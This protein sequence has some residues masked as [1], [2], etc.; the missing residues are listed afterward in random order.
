M[1]GAL[2][3]AGF[4]AEYCAT[5]KE[6]LEVCARK[7]PDLVIAELRLSGADGLKVFRNIRERSDCYLVMTSRVDSEF[8]RL[9][10]LEMGADDFVNK[11]VSVREL[12]ARAA[13]MFRRP[14]RMATMTEP[15]EELECGGGLVVKPWRREALLNEEVLPLTPTEFAMLRMLAHDAGVAC[16]RERI[17]ESVWG[18][19]FADDRHLVDVH[20]SNLRR[21]LEADSLHTWIHTVR[22][23]GYRLDPVA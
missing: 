6:A 4:D 12:R 10:C 11:P 8:D 14:R 21:K 1:V 2:T 22:G 5:G 3:R 13:A 7:E 20:L 19:A 17:L 9:R 15:R 23:V 16:T 18:S